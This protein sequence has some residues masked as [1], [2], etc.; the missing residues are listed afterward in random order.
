M[1]NLFLLFPNIFLYFFVYV[2]QETI[3]LTLTPLPQVV[4]I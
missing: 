2:F 3:S 1:F 4:I